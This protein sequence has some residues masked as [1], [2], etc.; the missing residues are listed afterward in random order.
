MPLKLLDFR[1]KYVLL[2]FWATWCGPCLGETP[3]LKAVYDTYGGDERF[4][5][6]SLRLDKDVEAPQKYVQENGMEWI[7]GFLGE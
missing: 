2:D 7:Q 4:V 1:G 3:Y 5:M 6:I